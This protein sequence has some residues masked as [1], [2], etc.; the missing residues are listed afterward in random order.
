MFDI[1]TDIP[2]TTI[3]VHV[4]SSFTAHFDNDEYNVPLPAQIRE[5]E[6]SYPPND[7]AAFIAAERWTPNEYED[8]MF[9]SLAEG[10]IWILFTL[11]MLF[12]SFVLVWTSTC[13]WKKYILGAHGEEKAA[14]TITKT[15]ARVPAPSVSTVSVV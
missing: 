2:A 11:L 14:V 8:H 1:L 3:T 10:V 5:V 9:S 6:L 4:E 7:T 15:P 13:V 12:L